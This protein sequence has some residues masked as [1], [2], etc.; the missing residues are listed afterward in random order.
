[1]HL[2]PHDQASV[3]TLGANVD[4]HGVSRDLRQASPPSALSPDASWL[5]TLG[6]EQ[7]AP[8]NRSYNAERRTPPAPD[9]PAMSDVTQILSA[10]DQGDAQATEQLLTLVY[11]EPRQFAGTKMAQ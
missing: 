2:S 7:A 4:D 11:G 6:R 10:I 9:L 5:P 8:G 3:E 1:M